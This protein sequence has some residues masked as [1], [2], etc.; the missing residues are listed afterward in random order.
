MSED[1]WPDVYAFGR[2]IG[3]IHEW[4]AWR[5]V[6]LWWGKWVWLRYVKRARVIKDWRLDDGP[7]WE[8]WTYDSEGEKE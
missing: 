6:R 7:D 4:F 8:F 2:I 1:K 3:P 5:P